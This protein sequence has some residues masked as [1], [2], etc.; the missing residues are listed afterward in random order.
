MQSLPSSVVEVA[1]Q[2][3]KTPG[4]GSTWPRKAPSPLHPS[5]PPQLSLSFIPPH[6]CVLSSIVC[7]SSRGNHFNVILVVV[8][9]LTKK[10]WKDQSLFID[11]VPKKEDVCVFFKLL[12]LL[13][14]VKSTR[15]KEGRAH[16]CFGSLP[17]NTN[18]AALYF[19]YF[20]S[21]LHL[22]L[23]GS[24]MEGEN[25]GDSTWSCFPPAMEKVFFFFP[26]KYHSSHS[27]CFG[28]ETVPLT[29]FKT[30][31]FFFFSHL[32][33]KT[34]EGQFPQPV[35]SNREWLVHNKALT[36]E[37]SIM[38][39]GGPRSWTLRYSWF[40]T[41]SCFRAENIKD[42]G[43][44]SYFF[45]QVQ[46]RFGLI[47]YTKIWFAHGIT[48]LDCYHVNTNNPKEKKKQQLCRRTMETNHR[49]TV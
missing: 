30:V 47:I 12:I 43:Q 28:G 6:S 34:R 3:V 24:L 1:R 48:T 26:L 25:P 42:S 11:T 40:V 8:F 10:L 16:S 44:L 35:E 29:H 21:T 4:S 46:V 36:W 20:L 31:F 18:A 14:Q 41:G 9:H 49:L 17:G 13:G 7:S 38:E 5:L 32:K 2:Q 39:T 23:H 19:Y 15:P 37:Y 27:P 33:E 45:G 22:K